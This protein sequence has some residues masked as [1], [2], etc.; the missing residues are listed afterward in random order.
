LP[1]YTTLDLGVTVSPMERTELR[2][3][4]TNVT[5]SAGLTEGNARAAGI[6]APGTLV[7]DATTGRPIF[8]RQVAASLLYRW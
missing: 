5:D 7:S 3:L 8:G 6:A 2:F 4:V 1:S